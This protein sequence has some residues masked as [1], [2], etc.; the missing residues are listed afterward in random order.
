MCN[1]IA[2]ANNV[3][4]KSAPAAT[5]KLNIYGI[6][7]AE[8]NPE[9][10]DPVTATGWVDLEGPLVPN[11]SDRAKA[12]SGGKEAIAEAGKVDGLNTEIVAP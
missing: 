7:Y 1:R 8:Y 9:K 3:K 12:E 6:S 11:L 10:I 5:D 4:P 2:T